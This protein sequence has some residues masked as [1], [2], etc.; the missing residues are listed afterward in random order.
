VNAEASP[1]RAR[2]LVR[3][4]GGDELVERLE[5]L[6]RRSSRASDGPPLRA[7]DRGDVRDVDVVFAGGGLSLLLAPLVA[8]SG[9]RVAV[10]DR[11]RIGEAHREWNASSE[12]LDALV[13]CGLVSNAELEELVVARYERGIC[14]WHEGGTWP[15]RG[16]LDHAV[17]AGALLGLARR[18]SEEAGVLLLD[19]HTVEASQS[20]AGGVRVALRDRSGARSEL[21]AALFVEARGASRPDH[22][23][24]LLCPT[25]GGVLEGL[26]EGSDDDQIDPR[27]GEILVTTEHVE[28]GRQHIWEAFPGRT[29]QTTVYLFYYAPRELVRPGALLS[30]YARFFERLGHYKRG[31]ARLVRPTFGLIPGWTRMS[32]APR[33][34]APRVALVGDAASR[35][36]PLTFCGFGAMLRSLEPARLGIARAAS[37]DA[38]GFVPSLV[39]DTPLHG[40]TGALAMMMARP[41]ERRPAALNRLLDTAFGTLHRMGDAP[42]RALLRDEMSATDFASFL[43]RVSARSPSVYRDVFGAFGVA[44]TLSWASRVGVSVLDSVRELRIRG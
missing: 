10:V 2:A 23:A 21:T 38:P 14:R 16:A 3:E 44:P 27:V 17:D 42:Y 28:D 39:H 37:S 36:S 22:E 19:H 34:R 5:H 9:V 41:D 11:A 8:R 12:E 4:A 31:A 15:V 33:P 6:D 32:A 43:L 29:G 35:H 25:V 30:L 13:S 1:D 40:G 20:G 18:A 7:P 24:D 26:E